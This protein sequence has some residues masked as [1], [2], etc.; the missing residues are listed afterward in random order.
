MAMKNKTSRRVTVTLGIALVLAAVG[1]TGNS[2]VQIDQFP[3]PSW[4]PPRLS[5]PKIEKGEQVYSNP[6]ANNC[7]T[8]KAGVL[9]FKCPPELTEV[10]Y[11]VT[12]VFVR[13]LMAKRPFGEV[14]LIQ[15]P[16]TSM[17]EA[18][19][20][21]REL[22]LDVLVLGEVP[23]FLDSGTMGQSGLQVDLEVVE[24]QTGRQVWFFSD[25]VK[26]TPRPMLNLIVVETRPKPTPP[27]YALVDQLAGNMVDLLC[28]GA[29]APPP[30]PAV[31]KWARAIWN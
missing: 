8:A 21:G 5:N 1:C 20:L 24:T 19:R 12:Q 7:Q 10:S 25:Q 16:Y 22:K 27:I 11:P 18:L 30:T 14:T 26:A 2:H 28:R 6:S 31:K 3:G 17:P 15:K 4:S 29:P 23:Y 13:K 9:L